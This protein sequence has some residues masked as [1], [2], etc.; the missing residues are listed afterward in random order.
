LAWLM[1]SHLTL[2]Y[3]SLFGGEAEASSALLKQIL[4]LYVGPADTTGKRAIEA[5]RSLNAKPVVRRLPLPGPITFGRGLTIELTVSEAGFSGT[6]AYL[7]GA[8]MERFFARHVTV[9]SFTQLSLLSD[10]R[11]EIAKWIP[12]NGL[13]QIG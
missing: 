10:S 11:G 5:I 3:H 7:F 9:N 2:N 6:G 13:K 8:V 4:G 1:L 12:R